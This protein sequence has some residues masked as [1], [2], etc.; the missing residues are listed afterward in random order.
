MLN[1]E[2][3]EF[4]PPQSAADKDHEDAIGPLAFEGGAVERSYQFPY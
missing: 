4:P 2:R 1:P 3:G